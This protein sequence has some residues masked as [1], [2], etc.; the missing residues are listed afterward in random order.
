M[1]ASICIC[2]LIAFFLFMFTVS[3]FFSSQVCCSCSLFD[4][5][6]CV[7][8]L[9]CMD[10]NGLF[11]L[12][13]HICVLF[14]GSVC[15]GVYGVETSVLDLFIGHDQCSVLHDLQ[16]SEHALARLQ[17][18]LAILEIRNRRLDQVIQK[19]EEAFCLCFFSAQLFSSFWSPSF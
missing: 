3:V 11:S 2:C 4:M 16:V 14:E 7:R 17:N 5:C 15:R 6:V 12:L 9:C 10:P 19:I 8:A 18:G 1:R 13:G